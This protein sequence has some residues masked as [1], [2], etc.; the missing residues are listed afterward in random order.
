MKQLFAILLAINL[1]G[2]AT[3]EIPDSF[4]YEEINSS[5]F[6]IASWQK[7]SDR[8]QPFKVY[9]EGDGRAFTASGR[10][11]QNPT[12]KGTLLREIAFGDP[13]ANVIYLARPCQFVTDNKCSPKYWSTARFSP[14]V[15]T[16]EY[17]AIKSFA[18][19]EPLTIVGFSGGAQVAGLLAVK[20][21]DLHI[22]KL[23]T[24]AGN[25]DVASWVTAHDV[26]P[27]SESED[28]A[29]YRDEYAVFE[30]VHYVGMKDDNILPEITFNFVKDSGNIRKI[31]AASHNKGWETAFTAI[32]QE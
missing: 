14:E 19:K 16:A 22:H 27:L 18:D 24:V 26:L 32:R 28:L 6:K 17:E 21:P 31:K 30:Q 29:S 9:I 25:L 7:I 5:T 12:P 8:N 20:Y 23:V 10:V 13:H 11:S 3:L 4:V 15:L 1:T 2:C